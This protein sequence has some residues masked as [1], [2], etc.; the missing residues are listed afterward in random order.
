MNGSFRANGVSYDN[1][2]F[3]NWQ[4]AQQNI[5]ENYSIINFQVYAHFNKSDSQL[6]A[7]FLRSNAGEHW[8][9]G[10]RVK[11]Y[12]GTHTTRD[13]LLHSGSFRINHRPDGSQDLQFSAG[14]SFYGMG[15]S[16]S[17]SQVWNLPRIPRQSNPT[18]SKN[19]YTLG[20]TI[21]VNMNRKADF[22]HRGTLQIP[23]GQDIYLF[24]N[25]TDNFTWTPDTA[26][27]D[28]IYRRIPNT[29]KT[30]LG[31][32]ITTWSGNT[33][34]GD[35]GWQ[36][37]EIQLPINE[38]KPIFTDFG[39]SD[40]NFDATQI[41]GSPNILIQGISKLRLWVNPSQKMT[42]QKYAT[43]SHYVFEF[44]GESDRQNFS[45][46]EAIRHTFAKTVST[47]G[48]LNVRV[49]A[50][51]SRGLATPVIKTVKVLP[52][53]APSLSLVAKRQNNFDETSEIE[54]SGNYTPFSNKN[55][56]QQLRW[57]YRENNGAWQAWVN[58]QPQQGNGNFSNPRIF[59]RFAR[60]SIID[61]EVE[62]RDKFKTTTATAK[63]EQGIPI[64]FISDNKKKVGIGKV[65]AL[66]TTHSLD[67]AG[68]IFA[69]GKK[70]L[71]ELYPQQEQTKLTNQANNWERVALG[72]GVQ[73]VFYKIGRFVGFTIAGQVAIYGN[74]VMGETIPQKFRPKH[75]TSFSGSCINNNRFTGSFVIIFDPNGRIIKTG[76]DGHNEYH[77]SG[78]Y[79]ADNDL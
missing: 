27:I 35:V 16:E 44:D 12:Q 18:F 52:Y 55:R 38:I 20:E 34:I 21:T 66:G 1:H 77:I 28:E 71:T 54:I 30:S 62:A 9:N 7:G 70:V 79:L 46:T 11:N 51:D 64:F 58:L 32:D 33:Q 19:L 31:V 63:I 48:D 13:H 78:V 2:I 8:A 25:I 6:D 57:R 23:D 72:Y 39:I 53:S 29:T 40:S 17:T 69:G 50:I 67:V 22:T 41:T 26:K 43:P 10:G 45:N 56:I 24:E 73:G 36:N 74:A 37:V 60:N 65:P 3:V 75:I 68:E 42:A 47:H 5:P 76:T 49:L 4:L 59:K 61:I 14:L 15:R